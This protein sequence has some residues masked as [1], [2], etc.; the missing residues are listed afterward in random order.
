MGQSWP[1][2]IRDPVHNLIFFEDN[3]CDRLLLDLIDAK[4]FQ[5]LRRIKQLGMSELVFPGANHS[6]FAHSLGV[7][8]VARRILNRLK[9]TPE[10]QLIVLS[11]ALL[12]DV[13]HGPF[14]HAFEKVTGV[15]HEDRTRQIIRDPDTEVNQRLTA[16]D[17]QLPES[18]ERFFMSDE[19]QSGHGSIPPY[20]AYV[21]SSQ[22]DADRFDYLLR[23]SHSAGIGYGKF[24]LDWLINHLCVDT[25]RNRLYLERKS[26]L[27]V[28]EYVFARYH[29]Y[30]MVYFHKATRAAEVMLRLLFRRFKELLCACESPEAI[31][32]IVPDAPGA[33]VSIFRKPD[34]VDL[35]Q[36][37]SLDDAVLSSFMLLCTKA[38]DR[39]L[40]DLSTG[41]INRHLYKAIDV[42][43]EDPAE[44]PRF[45]NEIGLH[46]DKNHDHTQYII[47]ED[48][49]ADTPYKVYDPDAE[50]PAQS[51][52][53]ENSHGK[54]E[55]LSEISA[56]VRE[57]KNRK[58]L[59][60]Y[61]LP[62]HLRSEIEAI[63]KS[64]WGE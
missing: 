44:I 57:L 59:Y 14:S 63:K 51:I 27:T 30:Q 50:K 54:P 47:E 25:S 5:R 26:L 13:G 28:E 32:K 53:V 12:H 7:M 62:E 46:L 37:L 49:P 23:D 61:Y 31:Q 40:N 22:L 52:Y 19:E 38:E 4:E 43:D 9:A 21:V 24:D 35:A 8:N 17:P 42:T 45:R 41:L 16:I 48:R 11:A 33:V 64:I 6:R 18:I 36:Y 1:R 3:S 39:V 58:V 60:R 34:E 56:P 20:L 15:N 10:Q 29:M 2:V 55:E